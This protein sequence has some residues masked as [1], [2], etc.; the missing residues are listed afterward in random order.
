MTNSAF[1][2]GHRF[3]ILVSEFVIE[4]S[5][6]PLSLQQIRQAV[7]GKALAPIPNTAPHISAVCIDTRRMEPGCLFVAIN[8]ERFNAHEFLPDAAKGGAVAALI[9]QEP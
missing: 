9:Q 3:V 4:R 1:G 8:G 7:G 2:F 6:K 5:M